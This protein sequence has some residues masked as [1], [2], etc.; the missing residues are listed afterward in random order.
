MVQELF[1]QQNTTPPCCEL[2]FSEI[3]DACAIKGEDFGNK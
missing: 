2:M 1:Q 3:Q